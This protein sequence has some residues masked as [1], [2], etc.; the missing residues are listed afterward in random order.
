MSDTTRTLAA[1]LG[2]ALRLTHKLSTLGGAPMEDG[3]GHGCHLQNVYD[4]VP[5]VEEEPAGMATTSRT[6]K[7]DTFSRGPHPPCA[8]FH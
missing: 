1:A 5:E 2:I 6:A 8:R 3:R 4:M 7:E